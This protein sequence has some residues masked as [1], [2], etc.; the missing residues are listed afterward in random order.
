LPKKS[1]F[2]SFIFDDPGYKQQ[3]AEGRVRIHNRAL[4]RKRVFGPFTFEQYIAMAVQFTEDLQTIL[5]NAPPLQKEL[6]LYR[7][8]KNHRLMPL[9][10]S[11]RQISTFQAFS[12]NVLTAENYKDGNRCCLEKLVLPQGFPAFEIPKKLLRF[13]GA[14]WDEEVVIP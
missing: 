9:E 3:I 12:T 4:I 13:E 8:L 7:G 1:T 5:L 11:S 14:T 6:V 2:A 10:S